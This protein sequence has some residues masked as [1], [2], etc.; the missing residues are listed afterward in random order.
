M[1]CQRG[2]RQL[3]CKEDRS[4]II[5]QSA[6]MFRIK[7]CGLT[8]P[9]DAI[10]TVAGGADAVGLN[11]YP[12]SKR[13]VSLTRAAEICSV[14]PA[15]VVKVGVFVNAPAGDVVATFDRLGL[16]LIQLHGDEPPD[17]VVALDN[18]PFIRAFRVGP[19]GGAPAIAWLD[20]CRA[21]GRQPSAILIDSHQAGA[22][23]GTGATADWHAARALAAGQDIVQRPLPALVLAG[24]LTPI[25]VADAIHAV[26]PAAV[27]TASGVETSPGRKDAGLVAAF[28]RAA[29]SA[30]D[31]RPL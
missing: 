31:D 28:V 12:G 26:R 13:C 7:I 9:A 25:N 21:V 11:F 2:D 24:G 4:S 15:G 10:A 20:A 17:Y 3:R 30:F 27:D 29:L 19:Q 1:R 16:D 23:G 5:R 22:Y 18:R 6:S 8:S 14:L